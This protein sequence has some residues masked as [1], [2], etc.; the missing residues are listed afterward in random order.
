MTTS[1]ASGGRCTF[2][3]VPPKSMLCHIVGH[4]EPSGASYLRNARA[5]LTPLAQQGNRRAHIAVALLFSTNG[6]L[7][8]NLVPLF[9]RSSLGSGC[10]M[11]SSAP[12]LR[13]VPLER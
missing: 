7:P 8:A 2:T 5:A 3:Q 10:R 9:P 13:P 1:T 12:P 11:P 6:A 4:R